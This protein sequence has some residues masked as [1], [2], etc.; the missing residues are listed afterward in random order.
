MKTFLL[1]LLLC[2]G[3]FAQTP[4]GLQWTPQQSRLV[5]SII[6][7]LELARDVAWT[8]YQ[9]HAQVADL[10]R[11]AAILTAL[12]SEGE[13]IGLT[14]DQVS[15]LFVPQIAASRRAQEEL[16]GA[17]KFGSP[18][19]KIPPKDL[20][21]EIRPQVIKVSLDLLHEWKD[22]SPQSLSLAFQK[23]AEQRI[24]AKGFSP[25]VARIAASPLGKNY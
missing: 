3:A 22:L 20:Q 24:V 9:H 19:P 25:D 1:F 7:R 13:K 4:S 18:Q 14:A 10:A 6:A 23:E 16:I 2:A 17:W 21:H 8:K 12:K 15:R 5:T 11:E